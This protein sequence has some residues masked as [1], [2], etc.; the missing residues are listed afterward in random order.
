MSGHSKWSTIKR[1]KGAL[2]A[3]RGKVFSKLAREVM[4]VAKNGGADPNMN[5]SLRMIIL[6]CKAANMPAGNIERA[7]QK[8]AGGGEGGDL[9]EQTYEIY[10]PNGIAVL[11]KVTTDS[12]NRTA[13]ELRHIMSKH[14]ASLASTGSVS[15]LFHRK[16][17]FMVARDQAEEDSLMEM[18]LEAGA[19]DI[20][21]SD[22]GFEIL[23]DPENFE[24]VHK[25]LEEN[26]IAEESAEITSLP[27]L[28]VPLEEED[29]VNA[30]NS[31]IDA[32]E[33]HDDINDVYHNAEFPE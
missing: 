25:I 9:L 8:G 13:S 15:R 14:N 18:A 33:D 23:T 20:I 21:G 7:I 31:F 26:G 1:A 16:G 6:K 5:A 4:V 27:E 28:S 11:A 19:E 22:D 12:K 30:I 24:A 32:L 17:Q 10:A 3:K 2:D 29:A